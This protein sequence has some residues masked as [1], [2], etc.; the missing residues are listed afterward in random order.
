[1]SDYINEQIAIIADA[2]KESKAL[3]KSLAVL[4]LDLERHQNTTSQYE[5][6]FPDLPSD[7]RRDIKGYR[8]IAIGAYESAISTVEYEVS[9]EDGCNE[10][11]DSALAS[12][13]KAKGVEILGDPR[14][15]NM[16]PDIISANKYLVDTHK[17]LFRV[18]VIDDN[19]L[20]I[21]T[22]K[23]YKR[24]IYLKLPHDTAMVTDLFVSKLFTML[25]PAIRLLRKGIGGVVEISGYN[26]IY[27]GKISLVEHRGELKWSLI[28]IA[29]HDSQFKE[30]CPTNGKCESFSELISYLVDANEKL[31][32]ASR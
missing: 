6:I 16:L 31:K 20:S 13:I 23:L 24:E 32:I 21:M 2:L 17:A 5:E 18:P 15:A 27:S 10:I 30:T 1:M 22:I 9:C 26:T 12:I 3:Q 29:I 7:L 19:P 14:I 4:R 8:G 25:V 11:M 28:D